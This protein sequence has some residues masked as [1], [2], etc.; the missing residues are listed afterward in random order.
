MKRSPSS[1]DDLNES[2]RE[3]AFAL[4]LGAL[5]KADLRSD[6]ELAWRVADMVAAIDDYRHPPDPR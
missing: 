4:L 2:L 6:V 3:R 1:P 5:V